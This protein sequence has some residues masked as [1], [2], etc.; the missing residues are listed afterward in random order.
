MARGKTIDR[1]SETEMSELTRDVLAAVAHELGGI[2][3]ALELRAAAMA[4]AIP[5]NDLRALKD[6][7]GEIRVVTRAVRMIRGADGFGTLAPGRRL[8]LAEW[9][10]L[11]SRFAPVALPRGVDVESRLPESDLNPA[12]ASSLSWIW[13]AACKEL[14][15]RGIIPPCTITLSGGPAEDGRGVT[16]VAEVAADCLESPDFVGSTWAQYAATLAEQH[17]ITPPVWVQDGPTLRWSCE[18]TTM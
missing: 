2:G 15:D 4:S 13:L 14:A 16:I 11:L 7:A 3:G 5:P 9:W 10:K 6:I 17:G 1:P 12:H 8:T 18:L